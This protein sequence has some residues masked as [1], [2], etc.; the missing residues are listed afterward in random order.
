M[1]RRRVLKDCLFCFAVPV[2]QV[3]LHYLVQLNRYTVLTV[4][5]C[6]D[7][8][9]PSWVS[10]VVFHVWPPIFALLNFYYAGMSFSFLFYLPLP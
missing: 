9:D 4:Y 2:C 5:G 3:G 10:V 7:S 1:K 8:M 6:V